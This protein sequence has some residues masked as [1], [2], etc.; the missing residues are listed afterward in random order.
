M[1]SVVIPLYNAGNYIEKAVES[2][3][4]Q[5]VEKEII[6]ID[7]FST[8][9][10]VEWFVERLER[11]YSVSGDKE[12]K[13]KTSEQLQCSLFWYDKIHGT[14]IRIYKNNENLGVART[15]NVGV[16][17]ADGEY[18]ALLD[19]DDWWMQDKLKRQLRMLEKTGAV[20][21]NTAR[22]LVN[23]DESPTG[24]IIDTPKKITLKLL[25]KTNYIN[26]SSVLAKKEVLEKYPMKHD[27]AHEDYIT[28]LNIL[29]EYKFVVGINVPLLK[30]RLSAAGKSRNKFKSACMT[31]KT[32]CYAG[33]GRIKAFFL[34]FSY[35][36][37]GIKKYNGKKFF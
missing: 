8:D 31:Y 35:T 33:Y 17:L 28:W 12:Y 32:Y 24:I 16:K 5:D 25:E 19:A 7:D 26:C 27:D 10:T 18:I 9:G 23:S 29:K 14:N 37:N 3:L 15:R 36:Y 4:C 22:E 13:K 2:V 34:M 11:E 20:L 21:C 30:Y 1:I 6:I